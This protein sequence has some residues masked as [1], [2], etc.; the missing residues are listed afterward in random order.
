VDPFLIAQL[1]LIGFTFTMVLSSAAINVLME[2]KVAGFIQQRYGPYRTGPWGTL[3]RWPTSQTALQE[4]LRPKG[5]DVVI[6]TLAPILSATAAFSAFAVVPWGRPRRSSACCPSR[7]RC[8]RPTSTS[9]SCS[10]S[11]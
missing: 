9:P 6:F 1:I 10:S 8:R 4:E 7:S 3:Q 5:A 2:R 11:P